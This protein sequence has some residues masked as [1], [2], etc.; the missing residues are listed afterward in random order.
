METC[1]KDP[2]IIDICIIDSCIIAVEVEKKVLVIFAWVTRPEHP[3]SVKD[4]A[5]R[6]EGPPPRSRGPEGP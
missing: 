1:I 6:P 2:C 4:E 3:K 5:K